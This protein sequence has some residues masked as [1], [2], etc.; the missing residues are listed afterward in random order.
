MWKDEWNNLAKWTM[1]LESVFHINIITCKVLVNSDF[2]SNYQSQVKW[3]ANWGRQNNVF[4]KV[5]TETTS[6]V[7]VN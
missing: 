2:H 5:L 7:F 4:L 6:K 1:L 3:F